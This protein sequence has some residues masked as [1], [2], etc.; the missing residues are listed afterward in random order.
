MRH[1]RPIVLAALALACSFKFDR[2]LAP[3]SLRGRAVLGG[4][5][6]GGLPAGDHAAVAVSDGDGDR[7]ESVR[8]APRVETAV[9]FALAPQAGALSGVA[10]LGDRDDSS[11]ID[12][13]AI[14]EDGSV[15]AVMQ[16]GPDGRY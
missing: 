12:V 14:A 7:R 11:G 8:V 2:G 9:D 13:R 5:G 3:G 16:S 1:L 4:A 10:L 6:G 15:A